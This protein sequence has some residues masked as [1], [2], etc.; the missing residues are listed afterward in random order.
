MRYDLLND[1]SF[2]AKELIKLLVKGDKFPFAK[3]VTNYKNRIYS[4]AFNLTKY[5]VT[6]EERMGRGILSK[7]RFI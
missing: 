6:G 5:N 7:C 1:T 3:V 4:I 2:N